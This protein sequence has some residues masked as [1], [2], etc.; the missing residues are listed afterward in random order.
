MNCRRIPALLHPVVAEDHQPRDVVGPAVIADRGQRLLQAVG[1]GAVRIHARRTSRADGC[2][3][4][5]LVAGPVVLTEVPIE[6]PDVVPPADDLPN[7][8][9]HRG[10]RGVA[11]GVGVLGRPDDLQRVQQPEVQRRRQQRVGHP[12]VPAQHGVLVRP[13]GGQPVLDEVLQRRQRLRAGRGEA[14]GT[15]L[16]DEADPVGGPTRPG[17]PGPRRRSSSSSG[18]HGSAHVE[19]VGY[20]WVAVPGCRRRSSTAR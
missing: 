18:H 4:R 9:L 16:A 6:V 8:A 3:G 17:R 11:L 12:A 14:A 1:V 20:P 13:E 10:D 5:Q 2:C 7:E 19:P 15:V